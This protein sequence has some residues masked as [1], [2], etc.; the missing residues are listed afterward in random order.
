MTSG[1]HSLDRLAILSCLRL[2]S[3]LTSESESVLR[4]LLKKL[5]LLLSR[6]LSS[7]V[8]VML[9][10]C[11]RYIPKGLLT[12]KGCASCTEDVPAVGYRTCPM[13]T[14]PVDQT[15]LLR[16]LQDACKHAAC[17]HAACNISVALAT[18][19]CWTAHQ[20]S[21]ASGMQQCVRCDGDLLKRQQ[22]LTLQ[23]VHCLLVVEHILDQ[24]IGLEL[25]KLPPIERD[26]ASTI[27]TTM[28]KHQQA[29]VYLTIDRPLR[30]RS[31]CARDL[32]HSHLLQLAVRV[33]VLQV[34]DSCRCL[35]S[36]TYVW[37]SAHACSPFWKHLNG[38]RQQA[39]HLAWFVK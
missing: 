34:P 3:L 20:I 24:S 10:L 23:L 35:L 36:R 2:D 39:L 21:Q 26:H 11:M 37:D 15:A 16:P 4:Y 13:P 29:F 33:A 25:N 1:L 7:S 9:P 14:L 32:C 38:C 5:L 30:A 12:K 6:T 22:G 19:C 31:H 27:L 17:K 8:L 28:L 18:T